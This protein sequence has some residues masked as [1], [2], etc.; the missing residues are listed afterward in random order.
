LCPNILLST[1]FSNTLSLC[2]SLNVRMPRIQSPLNLFLKQILICYCRPQIFE[3][4][5]VFERSVCYF[6]S[7]F[8]TAFWWQ[9]GNICLIS[10]SFILDKPTC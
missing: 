3:L 4:W 8:L 7:R 2:S 9:E 10:S 6:L 5:Y 1:L